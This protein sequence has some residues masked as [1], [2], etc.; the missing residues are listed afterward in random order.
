MGYSDPK[1]YETM[2]DLVMRYVAREDDKRPPVP[3]MMTNR[4][5]GGL[6]LPPAEWDVAD[7][8]PDHMDRFQLT[9]RAPRYHART[10]EWGT[11]YMAYRPAQ[12][13]H[14]DY[15][16]A[17]FAMPFWTLFPNGPLKDNILAQACVPMDD[18][19]TMSF[20]FSW[21]S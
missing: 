11:M 1:D 6:K 12:P 19:H 4:F 3:D 16:F 10:T 18:T 21:T 17:H 2:T 14:L 8:D 20:Q 15:R 9:D 7:I 13:G 5:A